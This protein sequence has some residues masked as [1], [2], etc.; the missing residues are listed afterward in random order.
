MLATL[1]R[2]PFGAW[3]FLVGLLVWTALL[4]GTLS[5]LGQPFPGARVTSA[6]TLSDT[7]LPSW[8]AMRAGMQ[9]W[10]AIAEVDGI[11]IADGAALK[12]AL[13]SGGPRAVAYTVVRGDRT[14]QT[15]V[16][17]APFTWRDFLEGFAPY[18]L[19]GIVMLAVGAAGA[20][21]KPANPAARA[22]LLLS[23][24]MALYFAFNNDYDFAQWASPLFYY[25]AALLFASAALSMTL[26]FPATLPWAAAAR[27]RRALPYGVAL[28][29]FAAIAAQMGLLG[30]T[31]QADEAATLVVSAWASVVLLAGVVLFAWRLKTEARPQERE[32]IKVLLMGILY[33]FAPTLAVVILPR[34]WNA[35]APAWASALALVA[36]V[37]FP[38]SV[39]YAIVRHRLFDIDK[40][41]KR[42]TTYAAVTV[43]LLAGYF[44]LAAG[45]RSVAR[46]VSG[47]ALASEWE[48]LLVT[49]VIAVAFVPLRQGVSKLVDRIFDREAYDFAEIVSRVTD[50]AQ[51]T[52]E[53]EE[54]QRVFMDAIDEAIKPSYAYL[55]RA[56]SPGDVLMPVGEAAMRGAAP[57][58][59]L[60][61]F[62]D[63]PFLKEGLKHKRTYVPE[64][65]TTGRL[66]P[67]AALRDHHSQPLKVGTETVGLV[68][69]GPRLSEQ[70][71]SS[72]DVRLVEALQVPLA[73][74]IKT[75]G[76]LDDKLA[77]DRMEQELKRAREVQVAML[78]KTLP[79]LPGVSIAA[80]S[81]PCFEA[82]GD[83]YDALTLE[84][85]R[86]AFVV[87]DVAGKGI[88]AAM[89][90]AVAK[91]AL[92][93]QAEQDPEVVPMLGALN[94]VMH[95]ISK[96]A[97][98]KSF[99]TCL[100]AI[101]DPHARTLAYAAAG[102]FP[103][104]VV[105]GGSGQA[106]ELPLAGG[107]PLGVRAA[108]KYAPRTL[109]LEP[110]DVVVLY[111]DG[112]TEAPA[113]SGEDDP[114]E[115]ERLAQVVSR[116]RHEAP[117]A[118]RRAIEAAVAAHLGPRPAD[119]DVTLL[120][121]K[122]DA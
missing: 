83:Y 116:H 102:H 107:F 46:A 22:N 117:E 61:V 8:P 3:A 100:Y 67:L 68:I 86:A 28:V 78:P 65:G 99:T 40:L 50:T 38:L 101:L 35:T 114:F 42:T 18:F 87:A 25:G 113:A 93:A 2:W 57:D 73:S 39:V 30:P 24:G 19:V 66:S 21:L 111:T 74:A 89:A 92:A 49:G 41:I 105:K 51:N 95:H 90:T 6:R 82:S 76:L 4:A 32:Q 79:E 58:P 15:W 62:L 63:D 115:V 16:P 55:L 13:R 94:R 97:S 88:A 112:V 120:V 72:T 110:G 91:A 118:I 27:W 10:D 56:V 75:A 60:K 5:C 98:A 45:I 1:K 23:F 104:L 53:V 96:N 48:N 106:L 71:F 84:G 69:L 81:V 121:L 33:A 14:F 43:G 70:P 44:G 11:P 12:A 17:I 64:T 109:D 77:K 34:A 7:N 119:D 85:G 47:T 29:L 31:P 54:L 103:P 9:A 36:W 37:I 52:L 59:A 20:I 26:H 108:G 80:S 122:V